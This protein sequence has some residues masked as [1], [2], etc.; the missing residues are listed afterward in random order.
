MPRG[1]G[2]AGFAKIGCTRKV[3]SDQNRNLVLHFPF[4]DRQ[5]PTVT[6]ASPFP[7]Y[8]DT[9]GNFVA[10]TQDPN[11]LART[12]K[13]PTRGL[14][15]PQ[16]AQ[17]YG[18]SNACIMYATSPSAAGSY[19]FNSNT[20]DWQTPRRFT[21]SLWFR[22]YSFGNQYVVL[23]G[24]IA[25]AYDS[26]SYN[27]LAN[28]MIRLES[29]VKARFY[30]TDGSNTN[31]TEIHAPLNSYTV[32]QD[33]HV[34]M[35]FDGATLRGYTNGV[36]SGSS[37]F[38]YAVGQAVG[39]LEIAS[40]RQS[41]FNVFSLNGLFWDFRI[42]S[43]AL[44]T[45]EIQRLYRYSDDLYRNSKRWAVSSPGVIYNKSVSHEITTNDTASSR[46]A[47]YKNVSHTAT[48]SDTTTRH[49]GLLF[50]VTQGITVTQSLSRVFVQSLVQS[51]TASQTVAFD[52]SKF[53][54]KV[55]N[56]SFATYQDIGKKL[57]RHVTI[58]QSITASDLPQSDLTN[59]RQ[60]FSVT[61]VIAFNRSLNQRVTQNFS[62]TH[63]PFINSP[64]SIY[65]SQGFSTSDST[66]GRNST[67]RQ[68]LTQTVATSQTVTG[69]N[70]TFRLA[71]SQ[72]FTTGYLLY[73]RD[74][75]IR[76]SVTHGVT[77]THRVNTIYFKRVEQDINVA[78]VIDA[79]KHI[80]RTFSTT[81]NIDHTFDK[82]RYVNRTFG[83][84]L[85]VESGL[86]RQVIYGRVVGETLKVQQEINVSMQ[87]SAPKI[88]LPEITGGPPQFG[89]PNVVRGG[90]QGITPIANLVKL[91]S[92]TSTILLPV[93]QLQN[94]LGDAAEV[95]IKRA[96]S[97]KAQA[98]KKTTGQQRF[99][100]VFWMDMLKALELRDW[101]IANGS[102]EITLTNWRGEAW[103]GNIT[104]DQ[105]Q[106]TYEGIRKGDALE[107]VTITL[108]F[109]GVKLYG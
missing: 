64:R 15:M 75:I 26:G 40:C 57:D 31:K 5:Q 29:N 33:T 106:F 11:T 88:Y 47:R 18:G 84:I 83:T 65:L 107:K 55:V 60:S 59:I 63:D 104:T 72:S 100:Y 78:D 70:S 81:T 51:V 12:V 2:T 90:I 32:G 56:Q 68:S 61:H 13:H 50:N 27:W 71:I 20:K 76:M 38:P 16:F 17:Q 77:T 82:Q 101:V 86:T 45:T 34:A 105:P 95:V 99:T 28:W 37:A 53:Y 21:V 109:Q 73:R 24:D 8:Y 91:D 7:N 66:N 25:P 3:D 54:L 102:K 87:L 1:R 94:T 85:E 43:D 22:Q 108:S 74:A 41:L 6:N 67:N 10:R 80:Y 42:Y 69:R 4:V 52:R 9:V 62:A 98:Y 44:S 35:T 103:K 19:G 92:G 23:A 49:L 96:I 36:L 48:F 39:N 30:I 58:V 93:P 97:G 14:W 79:H 46:V 89:V